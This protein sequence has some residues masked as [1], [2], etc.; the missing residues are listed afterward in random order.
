[1]NTLLKQNAIFFT[2][3]L[4]TP[5]IY[6]ALNL[7][8][9]LLINYPGGTSLLINQEGMLT[10]P[11]TTTVKILQNTTKPY[12]KGLDVLISAN[13]ESLKE[14][15]GSNLFLAPTHKRMLLYSQRLCNTKS[16]LTL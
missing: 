7:L 13:A 11:T 14:K 9:N 10:E 3:Q 8:L 1:M 12:S 6:P 2:N 4:M 16:T 5:W 15:A